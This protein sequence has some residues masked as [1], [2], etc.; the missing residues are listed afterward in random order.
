[1]T[2]THVIHALTFDLEE[3]YHR[4]DFP[5]S[6]DPRKWK[7]LTS[8]VEEHTSRVLELL[9][10]LGIRATF[11][12]VGWVAARHPHLVRT[13]ADLGHEVA[14]HGYWHRPVDT[15]TPR[16]FRADLSR[17]L[18]T[19][20]DCTGKPVLGYRAPGFRLTP[21]QAWAFDVMLDSGLSYDASVVPTRWRRSGV[22]CAAYPH[23]FGAAPTG[24]TLLELPM[25]ARQWGPLIVKTGGGFLRVLP[26]NAISSVVNSMQKNAL[27]VVLQLRPHDLACDAPRLNVSF[28]QHLQHYA[29][30][31]SAER[32]FRLLI[33]QF[34]FD[35]CA[36]V[37]GLVTPRPS[38][39]IAPAR[40][41]VTPWNALPV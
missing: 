33:R 31:L 13:L 36:A 11:F 17:S 39:R 30:L 16:Q 34:R 19:L 38:T 5:T 1:M 37:L 9:D 15:M 3:W 18:R 26:M 20:E 25:T 10:R 27:P 28:R 6:G 29:G 7:S 12:V 22:R 21:R 2:T 40:L 24:R 8:L 35:C 41:K 14:S 23:P 4:T 32:K